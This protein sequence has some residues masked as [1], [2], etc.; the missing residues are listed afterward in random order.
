MPDCVA[1]WALRNLWWTWRG[2]SCQSCQ[3]VSSVSFMHDYAC[4][5][6]IHILV[7]SNE[8]TL[9]FEF[10]CFNILIWICK[11]DVFSFWLLGFFQKLWQTFYLILTQKNEFYQVLML[12]MFLDMLLLWQKLQSII[13]MRFALSRD[14]SNAIFST[15]FMCLQGCD[16]YIFELALYISIVKKLAVLVMSTIQFIFMKQCL[17]ADPSPDSHYLVIWSKTSDLAAKATDNSTL[18][19]P[20]YH[21]M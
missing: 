14:V 6:F 7:N 9:L 21:R 19:V 17:V 12:L 18:N 8:T 5:W 1:V 15:R 13:S 20:H 2:W 10:F 16:I 11:T 4:H 3:Q